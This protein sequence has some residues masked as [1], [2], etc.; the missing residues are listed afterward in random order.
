MV[1]DVL[2]AVEARVSAA[3]AALGISTGNLIDFLATEEKVWQQ[4]NELRARFG[5]KPLRGS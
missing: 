1:L 3:A 2:A 5:Q 4:A